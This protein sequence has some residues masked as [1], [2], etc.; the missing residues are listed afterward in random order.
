MS[1]INLVI[2]NDV[3]IIENQDRTIS[4]NASNG[5]KLRSD[6]CPEISDPYLFLQGSLNT[7]NNTEIAIADWEFILKCCVAVKEYNEVNSFVGSISGHI[8]CKK[9]NTHHAWDTLSIKGYCVDCLANLFECASCNSLEG[10]ISFDGKYYCNCG[11]VFKSTCQNC[12][13]KHIYIKPKHVQVPTDYHGENKTV[14]LCSDC[15]SL[16]LQYG[17]EHHYNYKPEQL[18]FWSVGKKGERVKQSIIPPKVLYMGI[19]FEVLFPTWTQENLQIQKI[20]SIYGEKENMLFA[21][22]DGSVPS[23]GSELVTHPMTLEFIKSLSW[24]GL[25]DNIIKPATKN[26]GGHIHCSKTAFWSLAHI[27]RFVKFM[28][29]NIKYCEWVG[30]RTLRDDYCAG[31]TKLKASSYALY[32]YR[33]DDRYEMINFTS[34]TIELRFPWSPYTPQMIYKNAEFVHALWSYTITAPLH[35]SI[36][37]F[38]KFVRSMSKMYKNFI[39]FIDS[40]N[41]DIVFISNKELLNNERDDIDDDVRCYSC[42]DTIYETNTINGVDYCDDCIYYCDIC[43]EVHIYINTNIISGSYGTRV[44]QTC[45]DTHSACVSCNDV[46]HNDELD[47]N[48]VCNSCRVVEEDEGDESSCG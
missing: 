12:G 11:A 40:R 37:D 29:T 43:E 15:Y 41:K 39:T 9:C 7:M 45:Y 26:I 2:V 48:N 38:E 3:L 33:N 35:F 23:P 18:N 36:D 16:P 34:D 17:M 6:A 1:G 14:N 13:T 47:D 31:K 25:C 42:N 44:C 20:L 24:E 21:K 30:E 32:N 10:F 28:R 8:P 22:H 46:L 19:E 27:Y 4:Y 5:V